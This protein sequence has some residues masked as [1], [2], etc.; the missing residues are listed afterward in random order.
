ATL[1]LDPGDVYARYGLGLLAQRRKQWT[2]AEQYLRSALAS[3]ACLVGG[4]RALGDV[5]VKLGRRQEAQSAYERSLKF[6][7]MGYRPLTAPILSHALNTPRLMDPWHGETH[8][9]LAALYERNGDTAKA[10]TALRFGI[11]GGFG[12]ATVHWRLARLYARR[13]DW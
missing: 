7:L 4:H 3:D 9:R 11:A 1:E 8:V 6:G 12:N 5:L 2:K 13:C 10:M